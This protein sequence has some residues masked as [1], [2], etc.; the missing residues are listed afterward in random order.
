MSR[1]FPFFVPRFPNRFQNHG[2]INSALGPSIQ[3]SRNEYRKYNK[4]IK[5]IFIGSKM[6]HYKKFIHNQHTRNSCCES[7]H[8]RRTSFDLYTKGRSRRYSTKLVHWLLVLAT[9][10]LGPGPGVG[11]GSQKTEAKAEDGGSPQTF[12]STI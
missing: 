6:S 9:M 1:R 2:F 3:L 7:A 5:G 12:L 10:S 4:I 11:L 8:S